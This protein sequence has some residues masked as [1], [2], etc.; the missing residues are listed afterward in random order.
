MWAAAL[1]ALPAA[2][3]V[4]VVR[5]HIDPAT[6]AGRIRQRVA[7]DPLR[8]RVHN[9]AAFLSSTAAEQAWGM[10]SLPYPTLD[11]DATLPVAQLVTTVTAYLATR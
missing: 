9:D 8:T 3:D 10:L 7:D 5:C 6:A 11:L 2:T 4:V 1:T